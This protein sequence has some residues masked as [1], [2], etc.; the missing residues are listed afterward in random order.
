MNEENIKIGYSYGN[1]EVNWYGLVQSFDK[2][3]IP[4]LEGIIFQCFFS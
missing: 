2:A 4:D 3:T 1:Y